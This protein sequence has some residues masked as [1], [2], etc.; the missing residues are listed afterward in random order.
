MQNLLSEK[1]PSPETKGD[2]ISI[3][4]EKEFKSRTRMLDERENRLELDIKILG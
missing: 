4:Y 2:E 1:D 3:E